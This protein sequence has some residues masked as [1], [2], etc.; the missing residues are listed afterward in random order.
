MFLFLANTVVEPFI[1]LI[2][3]VLNVFV[4]FRTMGILC[5]LLPIA[6]EEL[7]LSTDP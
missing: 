4:D 6:L 7:L 5:T 3:S 2:F 1:L